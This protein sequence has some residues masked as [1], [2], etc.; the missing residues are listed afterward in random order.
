LVKAL[1]EATESGLDALAERIMQSLI[2]LPD[3]RTV[4]EWWQPQLERA[5]L[6]G[7]MPSFLPMLEH[8]K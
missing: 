2:L 4:G 3:G 7:E 6:T 1:L 8:N 5:Y